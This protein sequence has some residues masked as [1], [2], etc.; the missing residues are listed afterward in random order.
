MNDATSTIK[1]ASA[2]LIYQ[3]KPFFTRP[4]FFPTL[5]TVSGVT[6]ITFLLVDSAI[7]KLIAH[8]GAAFMVAISAAVIG[9]FLVGFVMRW[10]VDLCKHYRLF[11]NDDSV[12]VSMHDTFFNRRR[13]VNIPYEELDFVDNF[14]PRNY[15]SLIFHTQQHRIVVVPIW[16][17]TTE[18]GPILARLAE[19]HVRIIHK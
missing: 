13:E 11:L 7:H 19:N 4:S 2:P 18:P 10:T 14:A 3:S 1:E 5:L 9:T 15:S 8:G 16:S 17:M 6:A 12:I